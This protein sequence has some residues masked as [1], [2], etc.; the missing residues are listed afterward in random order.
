MLGKRLGLTYSY[1]A[2]LLNSST[3]REVYQAIAQE[4]GRTLA[5]VKTN[6][7]NRLPILI[8]SLEQRSSLELLVNQIQQLY[9]CQ[10][11]PLPSETAHAV[12][13]IEAKIDVQ[14]S[15]FY[16]L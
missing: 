3:L 7:V 4:E 16:R 5:Q 8:P 6:L 9:Q 13:E 11:F 12:Q 15:E 10:G 2:A 14:V 1:L